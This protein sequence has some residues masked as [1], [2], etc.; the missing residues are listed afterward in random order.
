[1]KYVNLKKCFLVVS[2]GVI[3]S[4]MSGCASKNN[5]NTTSTVIT[6]TTSIDT[7]NTTKV[8]Y[9]TKET[10]ETTTLPEFEST[11]TTTVVPE[12]TTVQTEVSEYMEDVTEFDEVI[13]ENGSDEDVINYVDAIKENVRGYVNKE[14]FELV[15]DK[16]IDSL[17]TLTDFI[18]Y[19]ESIK[20]VTFEQL[21]EDTKQIIIDS[22]R[23]VDELIMLKYPNYK[24]AFKEKAGY[25]YDAATNKL[26]E[27]KGIGEEKIVS[28]VG[29]EKYSEYLD[30]YNM[31]K[32]EY[33]EVMDDT[34]S[35]ID[36][37]KQYVK[38]WYEDKTGK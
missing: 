4:T 1:M 3:L 22:F 19:G 35:D 34:K 12:V 6:T 26:S 9:T 32:D 10:Y 24:E 11:T 14:N 27:W 18:F 17:V 28:K 29:E 38:S 33:N 8:V 2:S 25:A 13:E 36:D 15:K 21:K 30:K 23:E 31:V 16:T 37:V 20:G 7:K 5:E